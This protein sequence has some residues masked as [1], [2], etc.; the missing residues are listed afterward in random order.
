MP[1]SQID[2]IDHISNTANKVNEL[3]TERMSQHKK[4]RAALEE[5]R[6]TTI[7]PDSEKIATEA[8]G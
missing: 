1:E 3:I 8:L 4:M 7:D 6:E 2:L 5:I